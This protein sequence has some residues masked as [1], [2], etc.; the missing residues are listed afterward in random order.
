MS[1]IENMRDRLSEALKG[2]DA[3]YIEIRLE[4][5]EST[6]IQYRGQELEDI[7]C[8]SGLGGNVRA[9]V[10]GGWGFVSFNDINGLRD[11]VATAIKQARLVGQEARTLAPSALVVDIVAPDIKND[12]RTIPLSDKK[13]LLDDYNDIVWGT[14]KIQTSVLGYGD[15]RQKTTFANSEGSY[16]E[17][18]RVDITFRLMVVARD[19]G[20]V[21]QSS[22]SLGSKGD[23]SFM[24]GLHQQVKDTA[25]RAVEL[26]AAPTVRGGEYTVVLDPVLAGVFVHEAFGHLSEADFVYENERMKEIMVLGRRFG[27]GH[28]NIVDGAAMTGLRGSYKYDDEGV[29]ATKTHLIKEGVL[30]G[31]LHSRETAARMN[32]A[33]TGNARAIDYHNPPI[34]RMTN[35]Y[36]EPCTTTFGE[37]IADI[38]EGVY[39]R[40]WYGGMTSMEMFTFS[41][42]EAFMIRNGRVEELMRPVVLTGNVFTTLE[43]LDAIGNDLEMNEGGGCGKGGQSPLPVS[44]GSPHIRI[45]KCL[46]GGS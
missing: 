11:K 42:G 24:E 12:P 22:V 9:F 37:M 17:Q 39:A 13:G 15:G 31:R 20:D 29:S 41:A 6:R 10:R 43:N 30:V 46:V 1:A 45:Q 32:E 16:I 28:L 33:T 40:N 35:T 23:F 18:E 7:G 27:G 25:G 34:V 4:E 21:Q 36:I 44:N 8:S 26:L 2:Q 19:G 5:R 3:D 38:K 14:P